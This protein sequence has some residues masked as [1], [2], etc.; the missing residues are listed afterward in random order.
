MYKPIKC[1]VLERKY[2]K[3]V[4]NHSNQRT[5][6]T[7]YIHVQRTKGVSGN[8]FLLLFHSTHQLC[9]E[10]IFQRLL[11]I[12]GSR[13]RAVSREKCYSESKDM[14]HR[15][16]SQLVDGGGVEGRYP[17][18]R[19]ILLVETEDNDELRVL[20]SWNISTGDAVG[21]LHSA[22]FRPQSTF[23]GPVIVASLCLRWAHC[24]FPSWE[25]SIQ[26]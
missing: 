25:G 3:R 7:S 6:E 10:N 22:R 5:Y 18:E 1:W 26:G 15:V 23:L 14:I 17:E 20:L 16:W 21:R 11:H 2:G 9:V 8:S 4:R 19:G 24:K 13:R 12:K